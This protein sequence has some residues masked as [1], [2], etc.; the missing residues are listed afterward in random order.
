M[1]KNTKAALTALLALCVSTAAWSQEDVKSYPGK[2]VR[3]VVPFP[4]GGGNDILG[5]LLAPKLAELYSQPFLID[6]RPGQDGIIGSTFVS[7][8]APDGYTLLVIS[9][10]FTTNAHIH[11][12]PYDPVKSFTPVAQI[13][14]GTQMLTATMKLPV[15]NIKELLEHA[16]ANPG[17]LRYALTGIGSPGHFTGAMMN[18]YGKIDIGFVPYKGGAAAQTDTIAGHVEML[19]GTLVQSAPLIK[20]GKLKPLGITSPRRN[21]QMPDIPSINETIPG[22]EGE[23]FWGYLAPAGT[24]RP[25]VMKL[26]GA[27][28]D[29][30][31]QPEMVKRLNDATAEPVYATPEQFGKVIADNLA[32]WGKVAREYKITVDD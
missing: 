28:N 19:W 14:S 16:R 11:K 12:T 17:K 32:K 27:I 7:K 9:L 15:N 4:P 30:L 22:F 10:S 18:S 3:I 24:P 25:I 5:R 29:I 6:N 8:S 26:N 21:A 13:G 2:P 20:A 23:F 31:R 1:K